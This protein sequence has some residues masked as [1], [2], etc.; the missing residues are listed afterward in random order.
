MGS[1]RMLD[2][3]RRWV[4]ALEGLGASRIRFQ[5]RGLQVSLLV[6]ACLTAYLG[7]L[8]AAEDGGALGPV[9]ALM[10][11]VALMAAGAFLVSLRTGTLPPATVWTLHAFVLTAFVVGTVKNGAG[12]MILAPCAIVLSH[13]LVV[14]RHA[15]WFSVL[16]IASMSGGLWLHHQPD[17]VVTP[18]AL[19]AMAATLFFMQLTSRYWAAWAGRATTVSRELQNAVEAIDERTRLS[20]AHIEEIMLI[21]AE[22][23]LPNARGFLQQARAL[24]GAAGSPPQGLVIAIRMAG[25]ADGCARHPAAAYFGDR[26]RSFRLKVT[27]HFGAT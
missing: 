9:A 10:Y 7:R 8:I 5:T 19:V 18:R 16:L 20:A 25:W 24:C 6:V 22:S 11:G 21:D 1:D 17:P 23:G 4:Q 2:D 15:L 12:P 3:F 27:G 13:A 26:D 14:Y